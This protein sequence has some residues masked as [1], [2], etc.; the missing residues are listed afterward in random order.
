[1]FLQALKAKGMSKSDLAR[2]LGVSR[3]AVHAQ[4][5]LSNFSPETARRY[6]IALGV[7]LATTTDTLLQDH[8]EAIHAAIERR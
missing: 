8:C 7:D 5:T 3:Q 2:G 4:L 6:A 1:M